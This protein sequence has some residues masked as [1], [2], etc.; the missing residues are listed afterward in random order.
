MFPEWAG[1]WMNKGL[2]QFSAIFPLSPSVVSVPSRAEH[3][4]AFPQPLALA[5]AWLYLVYMESRCR[6]VCV[7]WVIFKYF[8]GMD[9]Y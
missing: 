9:K 4:S 7:N 1:C 6:V 8:H 2:C 5:S 3:P